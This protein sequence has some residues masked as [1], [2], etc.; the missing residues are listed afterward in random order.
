MLCD[1]YTSTF[2]PKTQSFG[3]L[4]KLNGVSGPF[5][6]AYPTITPDGKYLLFAARA[7]ATS[8]VMINVATAKNSSFEMPDIVPLAAAAGANF[9]NEPSAIGNDGE[10]IYFSAGFPAMGAESHLYRTTGGPPSYGTPEPV[11]V[12]TTPLPDNAPVVTDDEL[13]I[14]FA[15][16]RDNP[17]VQPKL[18]GLDIYQASRAS[19]AVPFDAPVHLANLSHDGGPDWPVWISPDT[20]DLY[21]IN[22]AADI[23]TIYVSH[24]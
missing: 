9:A 17:T 16:T 10:T 6:D 21:Y 12:A 22:K 20:C 24:R 11:P 15:S 2:V 19:T 13:E 14:F 3:F 5:Y 4:S 18:D 7:T 23:G 1:L 8:K